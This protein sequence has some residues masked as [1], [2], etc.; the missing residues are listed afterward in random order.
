MES[1]FLTSLRTYTFYQTLLSQAFSGRIDGVVL[2]N[3]GQSRTS[4]SVRTSREQSTMK[5]KDTLV[6]PEMHQ[7]TTM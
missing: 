5:L 2:E 4:R 3:G 7:I 6:V 1:G